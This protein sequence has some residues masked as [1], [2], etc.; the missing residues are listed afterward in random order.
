MEKTGVTSPTIDEVMTCATG[1]EGNQLFSK[2]GQETMDLD[3]PHEYVPWIMFN[4]V[5]LLWYGTIILF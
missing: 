5:S 2:M 1:T 4:G 3:P